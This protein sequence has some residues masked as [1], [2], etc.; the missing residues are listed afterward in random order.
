MQGVG[1][2]MG[3]ALQGVLEAPPEEN[4]PVDPQSL[5]LRRTFH[6]RYRGLGDAE[7]FSHLDL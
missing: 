7:G 1:T 2:N 5:P 3:T 4:Q 6:G